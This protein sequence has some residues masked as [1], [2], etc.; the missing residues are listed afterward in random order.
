MRRRM[1]IRLRWGRVGTRAWSWQ[2]G[3]YYVVGYW[4]DPRSLTFV[5]EGSRLSGSLG[6]TLYNANSQGPH[7]E[8]SWL[9]NYSHGY[10]VDQYTYSEVALV[11][12][13][14]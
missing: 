5:G 9:V 12:G 7:G 11:S 2:D 8:G 3:S 14:L 10:P 13:H 4:N 1:G 6:P